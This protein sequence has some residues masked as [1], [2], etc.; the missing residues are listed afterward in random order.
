DSSD[1]MYITGAAGSDV[2]VVK[3]NADGVDPST[4]VPDVAYTYSAFLGVGYGITVDSDGTPYVTGQ[5]TDPKTVS[6]DDPTVPVPMFTEGDD[7]NEYFALG[8]TPTTPADGGGYTY[9]PLS[10][11]SDAF[12]LKINP[13]DD[14]AEVAYLG[15]SG[16]ESGQAI[17]LD[18]NSNA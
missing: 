18:N 1:N 4:H 13:G 17:A 2:A 15:G 9:S 6:L 11:S 16:A 12:L 14:P 10:G 7:G 5:I 8:S 3:L